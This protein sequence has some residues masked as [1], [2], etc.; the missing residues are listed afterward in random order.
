M[1]NV[2]FFLSLSLFFLERNEVLGD[3][4]KTARKRKPLACKDFLFKKEDENQGY[5]KYPGRKDVCPSTDGAPSLK[6]EGPNL[7][8]R[9]KAHL[10]HSL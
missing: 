4:R 7:E 2:F 10:R 1:V 8:H 5:F 6:Q 9:G 3:K